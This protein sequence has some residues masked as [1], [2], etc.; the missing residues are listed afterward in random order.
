MSMQVLRELA[1]TGR[2]W[3]AERAMYAMQI[4]EAVHAGDITVD[5]YQ[6][7]MQ[8]LVRMDR[9]DAEADDMEMKAALVSAVYV[10]A[11]LV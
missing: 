9:L 8:D 1:S 4:T 7:L 3:V 6:E 5:E 11:N 2:P 10:V